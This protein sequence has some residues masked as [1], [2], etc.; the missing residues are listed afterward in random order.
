MTTTSRWSS[1]ASAA[2]ATKTT[3]DLGEDGF[4][5][6]CR[7]NGW[8][9]TRQRFA[10]YA[11]VRGNRTHP[12]VDDVL[13]AVRG[14]IPNLTRESVFRILCE[15]AG[16]GLITRLDHLPLA[17]FDSCTKPHG[18]FICARCGKI[19]DFALPEDFGMPSPISGAKVMSTEVR[20]SGLCETCARKG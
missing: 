6:V 3:K 10:V 14:Q 18:H 9:F 2:S 1:P 8:R 11:F 16:A 17:R 20:L 7:A 4:R 15:F 19:V 5:N 12:G 13:D